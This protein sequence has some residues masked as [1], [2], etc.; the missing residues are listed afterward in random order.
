M[1][2]FA[3]GTWQ[4][5]RLQWKLGLIKDLEM[6][7]STRAVPLASVIDNLDDMEYYRVIITGYFDHSREQ[8]IGPR[9]LHKDTAVTSMQPSESGMNVITPFI[10]NEPDITI[11]VNRGWVPR[12]KVDPSTRQEGQIEGETTVTGVI[13]HSDRRRPFMPH[14]DPEKGRWFWRESNALAALLGTSNVFIDADARS[15]LPGGP[16]GGQ[17]R[18]T[19]RNE[20]LQYIFTWYTLSLITFYLYVKFWKKP[21]PAPPLNLKNSISH[22]AKIR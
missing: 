9:S 5:F 21:K 14:N 20:H 6:R 15:T 12:S 7:T 13:R 8:Y 17:T 4:I 3:L 10:C 16:I 19:L 18:V 22:F 1:T 2:T 11:L